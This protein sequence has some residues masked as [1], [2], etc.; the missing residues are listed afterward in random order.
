MRILY[1]V[2]GTGNGHISRARA[3]GAALQRHGAT[4]N[5]LFS[6]RE[7]DKY[8]DMEPFGNY[9]VKHGISFV[10]SQG[11][12]RKLATVAQFRPWRFAQDVRSLA[13]TKY[14]LVLT[15]F[16]P[17]TAW[18]ARLRGVPALH[19]SHQAAL[20]H[21][22]PR[23]AMNPAMQALMRWYVPTSMNIGLHWHH[24]GQMVL[25]PLIELPGA[26]P[27]S[28]MAELGKRSHGL[29]DDTITSAE[30]P[31]SPEP[32]PAVLVY[33]PF[34]SLTHIRNLLTVFPQQ[35]FIC[36]HPDVGQDHNQGRVSWRRLS[37]TGF[38][39]ALKASAGVICNAGFE[40]PSEAIALGKK[41]LVKPIQGQFEQESN[42]LALQQLGLGTA[43]SQLRWDLLARWLREP[44]PE[45]VHY[46]DVADALARWILAGQW[47]K[48]HLV[49][50]R[51]EL[52]HQV[53]FPV[54]VR[55]SSGRSSD[56]AAVA[57]ANLAQS[58]TPR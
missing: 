56:G 57:P 50:L 25:P 12:I 26:N 46:P 42:A 29:E 7:F 15:D 24:F 49:E 1:G 41:L 8:F 22:V 54:H 31:A 51:N 23:V 55:L 48:A 11:R 10:V 18:A 45:P 32:E 28:A 16:E 5:F 20:A 21:A 53:R 33:L 6:G 58:P 34:E 44:Q 9:Q 38:Q 17:I 3:L 4:V 2:Q 13:V 35:R 43:V 30:L 36:Y 14:D 52:W 27:A 37:R 39:N 40:L 19:I 47:S